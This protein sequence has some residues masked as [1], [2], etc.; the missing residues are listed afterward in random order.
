[1]AV[2]TIAILPPEPGGRLDEALRRIEQYDR[3]VV[4]SANGARACLAR[5]RALGL[6]LARVRRV[7]WAAVGPATAAV[8]RDAGVPVTAVPSRYLTEAIAGEIG[9]VAGA[10]I[11]LPRTDA[12]GPALARSLRARGAEVEEVTAYRTVLAPP[13]SRAR[14]RSLV[15]ARHVDTVIFTSASTVRGLVRLLGDETGA[16]REMTIACI[17]PVTAAAV[18]EEGFHPAVV[19]AE[20]T[21][22]GLVDALLAGYYAADRGDGHARDRDPQ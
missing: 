13:R 22:D 18:V 2:P 15:A 12:A 1:V 9:G 8:L 20:H 10:R 5:A 17:G 19:A 14:L 3:V 4:T 11:L 21:A 16:L 6:D 7:R